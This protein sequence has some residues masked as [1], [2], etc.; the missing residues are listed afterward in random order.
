MAT[1]TSAGTFDLYLPLQQIKKKKCVK[2]AFVIR[3]TL[4]QSAIYMW[5]APLLFRFHLLCENPCW[6]CCADITA[7]GWLCELH[8]FLISSF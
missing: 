3:H 1:H 4:E 8:A 2:R 5:R 6:R 7:A